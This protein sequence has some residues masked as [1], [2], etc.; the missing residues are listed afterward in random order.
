MNIII[1][2]S[3]RSHKQTTL[4]A[5]PTSL[6]SR[7]HVVVPEWE[8]TQYAST[9][10]CPAQ[11]CPCSV[12]GIGATRQWII[13]NYGPKVVMLDDDLVF[14][15]RRD[16]DPSKFNDA[17][18]SEIEM[19]FTELE[20]TLDLYAH[21]GVS[22]REGGNR[23][24]D[25]YLYIGRMLRILAYRTDVLAR[26]GISFT[27]LPVMEDFDV[28]LS[29]LRRGYKNV[30]HNY[31]V[32]NQNG[33]D[34]SGGCSQYR[35]RDVQAEAAHKLKELHPQFVSV[36]EKETKQAWGGGGVRTDV[37]IQWKQALQSA[38]TVQ[39]LDGTARNDSVPQGERVP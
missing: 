5:L 32:H 25:D 13:E 12:K 23:V 18:D 39:V 30:I 19:L 37:R 34:L 11:V 9:M 1:P 16:D 2:S 4:N 22:T 6:T 29:L 26:E 14:A 17:T 7:V 10:R 35:T 27:R 36:V 21:A 24:H 28:T 33:S 20:Q 8:Y 38:G 31:M 3:G 15:T